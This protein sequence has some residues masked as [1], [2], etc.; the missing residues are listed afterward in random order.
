M[1][2]LTAPAEAQ[3]IEKARVGQH[4][5]AEHW[6]SGVQQRGG[7]SETGEGW[8]VYLLSF[9]FVLYLSIRSLFSF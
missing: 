1:S 2:N 5:A 8:T 6:G 4:Y 7:G 9:R 3:H